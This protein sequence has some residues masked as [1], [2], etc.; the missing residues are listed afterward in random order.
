MPMAANDSVKSLLETVYAWRYLPVAS[1]L[2]DLYQKAKEEQWD[3]EKV[4]DWSI[5]VDPEAENTPD[6]YIAIYG[7]PLWNR[8]TDREKR[9]LRHEMTSW[10]LSNFLHGEQG[11]LLAAAQ[12]VDAVPEI[13]AKL[14]GATQVV[15]EARHVEVYDRYLREK[16]G[17]VYPINRYLKQLLDTILTDSRW[18]MKFLGM[19]IMVEGLAMAAFGMI[20][21][22]TNEPLMKE[23][24]RNVMRDEARHVAFGVLA[25]RGYYNDLPEAEK[26]DREELAYESA[27]LLRDRFL[28]EEVWEAMG[29]PVDECLGYVR[30]SLPF[31]EFQKLL[32]SR[33][34]PNLKRLGLLDGRLR[35]RFAELGI[36]EYESWEPDA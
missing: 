15:D 34:V 23:L 26:R 9:R 33:I 12:L 14:Y 3:G 10:I 4:L 31:R 22:T 20:V 24:V 25:L 19:Q 18:D 29:I 13:D 27:R 30:A 5:P 21:Q 11:A 36:L 8:M 16:V 28:A 1:G 7:S 17:K 6:A 32:F 35:E 2:R